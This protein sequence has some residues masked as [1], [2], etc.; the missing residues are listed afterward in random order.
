MPGLGELLIQCGN[1]SEHSWEAQESLDHFLSWGSLPRPPQM[2]CHVSPA[3]QK[4]SL[5]LG[6]LCLRSFPLYWEDS[7]TPGHPTLKVHGP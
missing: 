4:L 1:P 6:G 7:A 5:E 2:A 3:L